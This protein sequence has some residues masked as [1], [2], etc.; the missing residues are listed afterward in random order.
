VLCLKAEVYMCRRDPKLA[1]CDGGPGD[2]EACCI[3]SATFK[4]EFVPQAYQYLI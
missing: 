3:R 1:V 2:N 4:S